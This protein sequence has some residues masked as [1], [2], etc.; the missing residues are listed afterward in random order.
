MV[1]NYGQLTNRFCLNI[2]FASLIVKLNS[3]HR[4]HIA[5]LLVTSLLVCALVPASVAFANTVSSHWHVGTEHSP[6]MHATDSTVMADA[7]PHHP[8][9]ASGQ[10]NGCDENPVRFQSPLSP[11]L[12]G[13]PLT[14]LP[15][16]FL[17][18]TLGLSLCWQ[19]TQATPYP[20]GLR[21]HLALGRIHV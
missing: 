15:V 8:M 17:Q 20:P 3:V 14:V 21:S 6:S 16:I 12:A 1:R 10:G 13:L 11:L 19:H 2:D 18:P 9:P 5:L 4:F 7:S